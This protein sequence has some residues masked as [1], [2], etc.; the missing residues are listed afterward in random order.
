MRL[1]TMVL[2]AALTV[3]LGACGGG[4]GEGDTGS[5]DP[6]AKTLKIAVIPKGTTHEFWK[7]V[8]AGA[9]K[10]EAELEGIEITFRGPEKEDDRE[11][12]V[13]LVQNLLTGRYDAIV[14]A[15]L[16]DHAL[17]APVRQAKAAGV[18]VVIIDSGLEG[19]A[20]EDFVSFVATDNKRGG[21]VAGEH[22]AEL[23]EGKGRVLM[24]RYQEG[25]ASTRLREEGFVEAIGEHPGIELIDPGR[26][27]GP[28]RE[29]A[30]QAAE[31]LLAANP[32]IDAV[33][34]PNESSTFGML[35]ALRGRGLAGEVR[36]VGFD[37]SEGLVEALR[38]REIDGLVVQ[39]PIRMGYLG[40]MAA[41]DHLRGV[42]V[43][44]RIDTGASLVTGETMD[45]P[46][47]K[48]L[49]SPDLSKYLDGG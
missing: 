25:S 30:L 43:E 17:V 23:L 35:L 18:P 46:E 14:L 49:I 27:A 26:F 5:G 16:D 44:T 1:L 20:G 11:Q 13:A 45:D 34:C 24:L 48:E 22:M 2:G 38:N 33:Y 28:T 7:S 9:A 8:H 6:G 15:P 41:V 3:A 29:T 12:Q 39:S 31:N 32:E 47:V 40:V 19:T 21:R 42:S 10:A 37:S 4:E 36:F